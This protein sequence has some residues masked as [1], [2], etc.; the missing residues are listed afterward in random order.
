VASAAKRGQRRE[1]RPL[2]FAQLGF[3]GSLSAVGGEVVR[4]AAAI[5]SVADAASLAAA[6]DAPAAIAF[7]GGT[8][9]QQ[10]AAGA[11]QAPP[12]QREARPRPHPPA[13]LDAGLGS[14]ASPRC[15]HAIDTDCDE[16]PDVR[17]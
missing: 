2:L 11:L 1:W 8:A 9:A 14:A 16:I 12:R 15:D 5:D 13:V 3:H 7:D 4:D 17:Q 10:A 6:D